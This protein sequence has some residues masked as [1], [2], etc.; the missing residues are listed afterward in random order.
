MSELCDCCDLIIFGSNSR[1]NIFEAWKHLLVFIA[2]MLVKHP[3]SSSC[4]FEYHAAA[5][6]IK[7]VEF[8]DVDGMLSVDI[9]QT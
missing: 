8:E 7:V 1:I 3:A 4:R 9:T 5:E 6:V 2:E